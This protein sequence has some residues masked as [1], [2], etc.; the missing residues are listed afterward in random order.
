M[1]FSNQWM[2]WAL[3]SAFF[4]A[5]TAIFAKIGI[6]NVDSDMAT[7][8]RTAIIMLVLIAFVWRAGKWQNPL[9]L[10]AKTWIFLTLS[11]HPRP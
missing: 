8:L 7:L 6:R 1:F 9:E 10:S 4:A 2:V 3:L 11:G 5:M